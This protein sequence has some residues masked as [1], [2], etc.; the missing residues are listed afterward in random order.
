MNYNY[1]IVALLLSFLT[2][3]STAQDLEK[4]FFEVD[5]VTK[6]S[7]GE[8]KREN[9]SYQT[10]F[11]ID[12]PR[13][14]HHENPIYGLNFSFNYRLNKNISAG[15]GSGVNFVFEQRPDFQNEYHNK[16]MLPFFV[17]LRYQTEISNNLSFLTDL[18]TGYQ[19]IDFKHGHTE[20]GY[21]F[22]ESGGLLLN[23]DVGLGLHVS[24]FTP[25]I[26]VG[27]E[28]NQHNHQ[29]SL[30]WITNYSYDDIIEYTN[31]YHLLKFSLSLSL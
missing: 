26:K 25:I 20:K 17:R 8:T 7:I 15:I 29:N 6:I 12:V 31:Y 5:A 21:L 19:Y 13:I 4:V 16:I 11:S 27:Y 18:N 1:L 14:S 10:I 23:L 28:L 9:I 2:I 3:E 24:K 30:G 22:Q